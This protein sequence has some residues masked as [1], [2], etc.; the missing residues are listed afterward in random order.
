MNLFTLERNQIQV[1]PATL[2]IHEFNVIWEADKTKDKST[3][4]KEL[5]YIYY[6]SDYKST[7]LS[8]PPEER[9]EV[10]IEDLFK[11]QKW[12]INKAV[13]EGIK[14]YEVLQQVPSIRLLNA[15]KRALEEI[16]HFFNTI[17]LSHVDKQGKPVYK[18][19]DLTSAM[20]DSAKMIESMEYL[21]NKVRKELQDSTKAR[22]GE[23]A[24]LFEDYDFNSKE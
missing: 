9:D 6:T 7:Y 13:Q 15:T 3:A 23:E 16:I 20:G 12:T 18:P 19:K 14:K 1:N 24:G 5:A 4:L 10:I 22:G 11:N 21:N 2:L 17:D 8:Y